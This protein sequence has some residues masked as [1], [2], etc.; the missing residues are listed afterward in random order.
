VDRVAV[1][2][3]EEEAPLLPIEEWRAHVL[4]GVTRLPARTATLDE[5]WGCVLARDV[6]ATADLPGFTSSAMDGFA[7]RASDVAQASQKRP[8]ELRVVGAVRMGRPA[9]PEVRDGEAVAIPTG[10]VVPSGADAVVPIELCAV[11]GD[12]VHVLRSVPAG[13]HVRPAGED[14]RAGDVLVPAGRRL[15]APDLGALAAAGLDAIDVYPRARVGIESTG[16]ELVRPGQPLMDAQIYDANGP[17]LVA[18]VRDAGAIP[19]PAIVARDEPGALVEV[20][21]GIASDVDLIVCS[22][23]VSAGER[24]PV[25]R[26]FERGEVRFANVAMQ[27]G[28]P[29][30]FGSFGGKPLFGLPGNPVSVFVSFVVFAYPALMKMMG[31]EPAHPEVTA[32]LDAPIAAPRTRTRYARVRLHRDGES[33]VASPEG[34]HQSNLLATFARADGLAIIPAGET[35]AA[36]ESCRVIPIR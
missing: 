14:A 19:A 28:R 15:L 23:G 20:L 7:V 1:R 11:H 3:P 26:A 18:A 36:G 5:A 31:R 30:A 17:I 12:R 4:A 32:V 33:L 35:I 29:Q 2:D 8:V 34:G 21:E 27:P 22:G 10:G 9:R 6:R 16:D 13:K 25:K 24:D